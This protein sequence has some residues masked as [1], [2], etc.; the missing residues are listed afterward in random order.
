MYS[1]WKIDS[2]NIIVHT[3]LLCNQEQ[4]IIFLI[5]T[6]ASNPK[7]MQHLKSTHYLHLYHHFAHTATTGLYSNTNS[8]NISHCIRRWAVKSI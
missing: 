1:Y 3:L 7:H 8:S 6:N 4:N 2:Y 5:K